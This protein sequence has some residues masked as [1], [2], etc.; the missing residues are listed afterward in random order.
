MKTFS[1]I[2]NLRT[3]LKTDG[4]PEGMESLNGIRVLTAIWLI[5]G[6][7]YFMR[8]P[9]T[10]KIISTLRVPHIPFAFDITS[11]VISRCRKFPGR[12]TQTFQIVFFAT[13][14]T[15]LVHCRHLLLLK[16]YYYFYAEIMFN[17]MKYLF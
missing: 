12:R 16:V 3:F 13:H 1:L 10:S 5:L 4:T 14:R 15:I 6:H 11:H 8:E 7:E 9:I 17:L 2:S